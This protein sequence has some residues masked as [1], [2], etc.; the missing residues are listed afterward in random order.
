MGKL[1]NV[2]LESLRIKNGMNADLLFYLL[3]FPVTSSQ[4]ACFLVYLESS[5]RRQTVPASITDTAQILRALLI[6]QVCDGVPHPD[7]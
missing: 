1:S 3:G 5:E 2:E 7:P 6:I 4:L